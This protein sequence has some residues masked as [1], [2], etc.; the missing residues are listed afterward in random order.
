VAH[1]T[2]CDHVITVATTVKRPCQLT[3]TATEKRA[4]EGKCIPDDVLQP[5]VNINKN[6]TRCNS[7][8]IFIYPIGPLWREVAVPLL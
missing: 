7:M 6:P 5:A 8:Q 4:W 1:K 3:I 2:H